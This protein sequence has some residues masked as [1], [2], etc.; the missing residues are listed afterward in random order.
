MFNFFKKSNKSS[1]V[2][3]KQNETQNELQNETQDQHPGEFN[4]AYFNRFSKNGTEIKA[5]LTDCLPLE[6]I[7]KMGHQH[8]TVQQTPTG[9]VY[10]NGRTG[11]L[12]EDINRFFVYL[13]LQ[14]KKLQINYVNNI[15]DVGDMNTILHYSIDIRKID[16]VILHSYVE[17]QKECY[18]MYICVNGNVYVIHAWE[19]GTS[20]ETPKEFF[21]QAIY[22]IESSFTK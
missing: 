15:E 6:D 8:F 11:M 16:R 3:E 7:I 14:D 13:K 9:Q 21:G 10:F 1:N 19:F 18:S 17:N 22:I 5:G 12:G 2:L 4:H 20:G